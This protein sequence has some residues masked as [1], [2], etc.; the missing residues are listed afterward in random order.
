MYKVVDVF[1]RIPP[2][3][4]KD[5]VRPE[6]FP[7]LISFQVP[8]EVPSGELV[9]MGYVVDGHTA[10]RSLVPS[11][12]VPEVSLGGGQTTVVPVKSGLR[13]VPHGFVKP[14]GTMI[15]SML[16]EAEAELLNWFRGHGY[17]VNFR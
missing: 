8:R 2:N 9:G 11:Q 13:Q 15:G 5:D 4:R 6:F 10:R 17:H 3:V 12:E 7:R 16:L 1:V 14:D